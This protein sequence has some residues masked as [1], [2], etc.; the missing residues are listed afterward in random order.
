MTDNVCKPNRNSIQRESRNLEYDFIEVT[1]KVKYTHIIVRRFDTT[2]YKNI[3]VS[4]TQS[5]FRVP[6]ESYAPCTTNLY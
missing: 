4:I 5:A 3:D 6:L 1:H 2:Y